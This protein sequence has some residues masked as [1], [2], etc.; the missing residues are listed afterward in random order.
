MLNLFGDQ[1]AGPS[2][3]LR[4]MTL[5]DR[6]VGEARILDR[7]PAVQAELYQ[8]LGHLYQQLGKLDE[9]D[10]LLSSA[11]ER[12]RAIY[13]RDHAE[14]AESLVALG[15]LRINQARLEE[16]ERLVR[17][18]LEMSRR[19]LPANDPVTARAISALGKV[20]EHRGR[21]PQA[22]TM[23]EEAIRLQSDAGAQ[24]EDPDLADSLTE[25]AN[26]QFYL[27]H[28]AISD[29]LDRRL[30]ATHRQTYGGRHPLVADDL[31]NL[32]AIQ[33]NLGHSS[34][35]EA[36]AREALDINR[37]WYGQDHPEVA[38][39]LTFLGQ[40]L[41]RESA[42]TRRKTR[43]NSRSPFRN[44]STARGTTA[45]RWCLTNWETWS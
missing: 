4:V 20:L 31:M 35:A 14:I 6:G 11:L 33:Y 10:Q 40:A 1:T 43:C 13:G 27:G 17:E 12:R 39:S 19:I 22:I 41:G 7:E 8:T 3:S 9:A 42:T 18:G 23:L 16:A 34:E 21:Y 2:D 29:S 44:A 32:S 25:L 15:L 30:L 24:A 45:W 38:S 28:Y 36:F 5:L 37:S 26:T